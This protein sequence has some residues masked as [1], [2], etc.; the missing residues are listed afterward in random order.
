MSDGPTE[1]EAPCGHPIRFTPGLAPALGDVIALG[2]LWPSA[3]SVCGG[4]AHWS[5]GP[6]GAAVGYCDVHSP[7]PPE[8]GKVQGG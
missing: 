1:E 5:I 7:A 3:C 8:K 2:P 6:I 4:P